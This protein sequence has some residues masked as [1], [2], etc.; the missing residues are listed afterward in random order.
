MK[1]F[2]PS[3]WRSSD[4]K[5]FLRWDPSSFQPVICIRMHPASSHPLPTATEVIPNSPQF[6]LMF[7]EP[8]IV[9][10]HYM[11]ERRDVATSRSYVRRRNWFA[12]HNLP[13][14]GAA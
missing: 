14:R 5:R 3:R 13:W 8:L 10:L 2:Q 11:A 9:H 12:R 1:L 4:S 6:G 7:A